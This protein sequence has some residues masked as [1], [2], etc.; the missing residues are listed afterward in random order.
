MNCPYLVPA[1]LFTLA[2]SPSPGR[3]LA[4]GSLLMQEF[5]Q[6]VDQKRRPYQAFEESLH[7]LLGGR[8]AADII[9]PCAEEA[10][11]I[12][13]I[14]TALNPHIYFLIFLFAWA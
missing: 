3:G 9:G 13:S 5:E 2:T 7:A 11:S 4:G 1:V 10:Q 12:E 6:I 14:W 8:G